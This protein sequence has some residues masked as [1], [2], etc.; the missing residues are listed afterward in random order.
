L[1]LKGQM[2]GSVSKILI[3]SGLLLKSLESVMYLS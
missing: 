3:L 1:I 2:P